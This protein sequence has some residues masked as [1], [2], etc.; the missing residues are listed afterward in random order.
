MGYG[1]GASFVAFFGRIGGGIYHKAAELGAD[2]I[3]KIEN[4]LPYHSP[5]NMAT[6]GE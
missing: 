4:G 1:F 2:F 5:S 6:I 3:G